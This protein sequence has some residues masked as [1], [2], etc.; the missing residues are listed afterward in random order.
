MENRLFKLKVAELKSICDV[1]AV[2]RS[3]QHDK[4]SLVTCLL[5][6]LR[7]P[8]AQLVKGYHKKA[9]KKTKTTTGSASSSKLDGDYEQPVKG[10]MP[11]DEQLR[12]WVRAFVQC[13]DMEK[14]TVKVALEIAG[15]K[16]GVNLSEKKD[17]IKE[18]LTEEM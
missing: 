10:Q 11:T 2:D 16:F 4:E 8:Q 1:L 7:E 6:F 3:G 5:N 13:F 9:A 18:L 15:D 12:Q 14:A 17:R